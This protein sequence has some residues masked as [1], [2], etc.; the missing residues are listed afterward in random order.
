M[1]LLVVRDQDYAS[2]VRKK[3]KKK[4][5][6]KQKQEQQPPPRCHLITSEDFF[7]S[8]QYLSSGWQKAN[9]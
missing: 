8:S 1:C 7:E 3:P 4:Q 2:V 5:K 6:Q 9:L